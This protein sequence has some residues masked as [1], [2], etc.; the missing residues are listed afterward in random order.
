MH[1]PYRGFSPETGMSNLSAILRRMKKSECEQAI[2]SL[3]HEWGHLNS[4]PSRPDFQP[5][6]SQFTSWLQERGYGG[7]L[8]FR[9][10]VGPEYD[11]E[12]WF[13]Q[14]FHQTWRN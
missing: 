2:R 9:S 8:H 7:Y 14:E 5:S 1:C 3:C 6:F 13:D 10:V 11:A 12:M 4:I